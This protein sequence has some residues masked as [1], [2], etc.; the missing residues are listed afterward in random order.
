MEDVFELKC[1]HPQSLNEAEVVGQLLH[2]RWKAL[3]Y[4]RKNLELC[5]IGWIHRAARSKLIHAVQHVLWAQSGFG[6]AL[7]D[8]LR[9]VFD[10]V[11]EIDE[12][13]TLPSL[14]YLTGIPY[15][16]FLQH[17]VAH[18][19]VSFQL[20]NIIGHIRKPH[21]RALVGQ[22]SFDECDH[23]LPLDQA[24]HW[25][26]HNPF[27]LA[28]FQDEMVVSELSLKPPC[29]FSENVADGNAQSV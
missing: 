5:L 21:L 8:I 20:P 3:A 13:S 23:A 10:Q 19:S 26:P 22:W 7:V 25:H 11:I 18:P 29:L 12:S 27:L 14:I 9:Q 15:I 17:S 24:A 6:V 28:A 2:A 4:R 16:A 1:V